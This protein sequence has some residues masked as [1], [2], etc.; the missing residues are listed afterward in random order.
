M[1]QPKNTVMVTVSTEYAGAPMHEVEIAAITAKR[2]K[3]HKPQ[4]ML[5]IARKAAKML[6]IK[7]RAD[8]V[9]SHYVEFKHLDTIR[10]IYIKIW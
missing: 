6:G 3:Q 4:A 8:F 7:G 1:P 2:A 5:V 9:A 10:K